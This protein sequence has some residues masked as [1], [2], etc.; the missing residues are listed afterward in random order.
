MNPN[1]TL[2]PEMAAALAKHYE[3]YGVGDTPKQRHNHWKKFYPNT[4][5][6]HFE[7]DEDLVNAY[8]LNWLVDTFPDAFPMC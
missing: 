6:S 5:I 8:E 7:T 1:N 4:T 2:P 3:D